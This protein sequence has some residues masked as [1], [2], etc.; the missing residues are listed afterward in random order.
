MVVPGGLCAVRFAVPPPRSSPPFCFCLL[1]TR[2]GGR[3]ETAGRCGT[4]RVRTGQPGRISLQR[5]GGKL[6]RRTDAEPQSET[7]SLAARTP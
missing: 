6:R 2:L 5:D 4:P 3:G 7:P 1:H